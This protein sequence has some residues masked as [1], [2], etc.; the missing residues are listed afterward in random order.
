MQKTQPI[1]NLQ[2]PSS[3]TKNVIY[4]KPAGNTKI[5]LSEK[6][7]HSIFFLSVMPEGDW[8]K[9]KNTVQ[10]RMSSYLHKVGTHLSFN[11]LVVN[12]FEHITSAT[13]LD[14]NIVQVGSH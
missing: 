14:L 9:E 2:K 5:A 7:D 13:E 12:V 1:C 3:S 11:Y 4:H 10:S 6:L 8:R